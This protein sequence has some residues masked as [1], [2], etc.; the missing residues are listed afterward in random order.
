MGCD[1][2]LNEWCR[3][4]AAACNLPGK[5]YLLARLDKGAFWTDVKW[6]CFDPSCLVN[7]ISSIHECSQYC[8]RHAQLQFIKDRCAAGRYTLT[9][10]ED[11]AVVSK[12]M[13]HL[14]RDGWKLR[15]I[16]TSVFDTGLHWND[17]HIAIWPGVILSE[18]PEVLTW[19][20]DNQYIQ[21]PHLPGRLGNLG[22]AL[23]HI[24][25]WY[26]VSQRPSNEMVFVL[27]DNA[28]FTRESLGA[29]AHFSN[30]NFDFLNL[31]VL[32]PEGTITNEPGVLRMPNNVYPHETWFYSMPNLWLSS[33]LITPHGARKLL[34]ELKRV[35]CDA[36][37]DVHIIDRCV[38]FAIH[39]STD[40]AGYVVNHARYFGHVETGGDSRKDFNTA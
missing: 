24:K 16:E 33:Y 29:I 32:R 7:E 30:L 22:A 23:A 11:P 34:G 25:L 19:A 15:R 26:N 2:E 35:R 10:R 17:L 37:M 8:T 39:S 20:I 28:L 18:T 40:Y 27:E 12:F 1:N 38:T 14:N 4:P 9:R 3:S 6:R 31:R 5:Q 13:V 36:S 21:R